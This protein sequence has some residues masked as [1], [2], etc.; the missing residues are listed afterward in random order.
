[1]GVRKITCSYAKYA[2][3]L[4]VP[5]HAGLHPPIWACNVFLMDITK[6]T[7]RIVGDAI[8]ASGKTISEIAR[9][10]VIPRQ[11]LSRRLTGEDKPFTTTELYAIG[12]S[13]GVRAVDLLPMDPLDRISA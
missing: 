5:D 9:E 11:T 12:R 3:R 1:M 8:E 13:I 10:A 6:E 7:A 4:R 2:H